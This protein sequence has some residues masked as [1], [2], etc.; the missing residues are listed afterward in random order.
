MAS[1]TN[2]GLIMDFFTPANTVG[3][4]IVM[5]AIRFGSYIRLTGYTVRNFLL[6]LLT[7]LLSYGLGL[8]NVWLAPVTLL[9]AYIIL[10]TAEYRAEKAVESVND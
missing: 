2:Q 7:I 10:I 1:N 8:L 3:I 4:L 6:A 5:N 9:V